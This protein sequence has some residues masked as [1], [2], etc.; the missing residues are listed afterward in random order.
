M[1]IFNSCLALLPLALWSGCGLLLIFHAYGGHQFSSRFPRSSPQFSSEEPACLDS[2]RLPHAYTQEASGSGGDSAAPLVL[3]QVTDLHVSDVDGLSGKDNVSKFMERVVPMFKG[4]ADAVVITGDLV[5]AKQYAPPPFKH[6]LGYRSEQKV[7]EWS[8]Y[9]ETVAAAT[10]QLG[11]E[12]AWITVPGNHDVFGTRRYYDKYCG[13]FPRKESGTRVDRC[14]SRVRKFNFRG[15]SVVAVDPTLIPSP[16]RPLNFFGSLN[17]LCPDTLHELANDPSAKSIVFLSH[18]P[19]AVLAGVRSLDE[20][21]ASRTAMPCSTVLLS[22]HLHNM[23]GIFPTGMQAVS[24]S[25]RLELQLPDLYSAGFFRIFAV[26]HGLPSWTDYNIINN[27]HD[28]FAVVLNIPR[29]GLC[30]PGAGRAALMS[31]HI[32]VLVVARQ[33]ITVKAYI[34][35]AFVGEALRNSGDNKNVYAIPWDSSSFSGDERVHLLEIF[36]VATDSQSRVPTVSYYFALD[37]RSVDGWESRLRLLGSSLFTLSDFE[38]IAIR[39]VYFGLCSCMVLCS[40][41]LYFTPQLRSKAIS[42]I[43][44]TL[45]LAAHGPFLISVDLNDSGGIGYATLGGVYMQDGAL[46][47]AV[48]PYFAMFSVVLLAMLPVCYCCCIT[49]LYPTLI[50]SSLVS[51][52]RCLAWAR[53]FFWTLNIAGA[54]GLTAAF[55]SPSCV[56]LSVLLLWCCIDVSGPRMR[57]VPKSKH[58]AKFE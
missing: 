7:S 1:T 9:N 5:N 44:A 24:Y 3:V 43:A 47:G 16:H 49:G 27:V 39:S 12:T 50:P 23:R 56:P 54:H 22:G 11:D 52:I 57:Q 45:W 33:L 2:S 35:G 58:N 53:S 51:L 31:S 29:A 13:T 42:F 46:L 32:R 6:V 20:A 55:V 4:I 15:H 41:M 37:G 34:D 14:R 10:A 18:Y 38:K 26:E 8:W 48:D 25:G 17:S 40:V 19:S 36:V 30:V 21:V 28:A